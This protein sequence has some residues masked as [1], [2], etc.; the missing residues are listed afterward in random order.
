[1]VTL[2][3][4]SVSFALA[5]AAVLFHFVAINWFLPVKEIVDE[6]PIINFDHPFHQERSADR[7][8]YI[9][10]GGALWGYNPRLMAGYI[11][12]I[13]VFNDGITHWLNRIFTNSIDRYVIYKFWILALL[14]LPLLTAPIATSLFGLKNSWQYSIILTVLILNSHIEIRNYFMYGMAP[15]VAANFVGLIG[16]ASFWR[17]SEAPRPL[18][19]TKTPTVSVLENPLDGRSFAPIPVTSGNG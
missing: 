13:L 8:Q 16:I 17:F 19:W 7:A 18:K 11:D 4:K 1:M 3:A 2:S 9:E 14:I 10:D 5:I 6:S 12:G 15:F